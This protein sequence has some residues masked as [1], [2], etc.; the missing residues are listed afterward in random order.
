LHE[1]TNL[2]ERLAAWEK[3]FAQPTTNWTLLDPKEWINFATKFEKQEDGSLLGG[4]DIQAGGVMRVWLDTPLTNIT[5]FRLEA[6]TN[7]NLAYN[8][9]G[10]LGKGSFLVKEFTVEAYAQSNPTVTNKIKFRRALAD[11]EAPGFSITNA[12]DG[13]T[14]T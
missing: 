8:G 1:T 7:A 2:T 5:G 10:V 6:L 13:N 4:G 9:P 3:T 11:A 14:D 12:I